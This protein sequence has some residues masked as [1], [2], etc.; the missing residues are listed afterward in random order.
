[1]RDIAALLLFYLAW[2]A[3]RGGASP[4]PWH[5]TSSCYPHV[6]PCSQVAYFVKTEVIE[7]A[8]LSAH[9]EIMT[10]MRWLANARKG[11]M[12]RATRWVARRLGVLRPDSEFD[13]DTLST[14]I[15]FMA[16]QLVYTGL[17]LAPMPLLYSSFGAGLALLVAWCAIVLFN[18]ANFYFEVFAVRYAAG[19]APPSGSESDTSRNGSGGDTGTD[20]DVD[21]HD[22][23]AAPRVASRT[24]DSATAARDEGTTTGAGAMPMPQQAAESEA[25]GVNGGG[26][27][28][29]VFVR[30]GDAMESKGSAAS[31]DAQVAAASALPPAA[32]RRRGSRMAAAST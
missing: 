28:G 30:G 31:S 3:S 2:Q 10:S 1:V 6:H 18:G 12:Y 32:R 23:D 24:G 11:T 20:S 7:A 13:S 19:K 27:C 8:Y 9:P 29:A 5:A 22:P 4:L 26:V 15:S 17:T 16:A 21:R 14:K 25:R